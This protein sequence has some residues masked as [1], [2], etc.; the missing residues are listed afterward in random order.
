MRMKKA[1]REF[2]A[3]Q[4][5]CRVATVSR[6]GTPHNVPVCPILEGERI[7]F[8]SEAGA[9]KVQNIR[10]TGQVALAFDEY[11]EAWSGLKGVLIRGKGK[12][13]ESGPTFRRIRKLLY[14]RF[15]QYEGYAALEEKDTVIVEV[16][17]TRAFSW[18][19]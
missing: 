1:E 18:G 6:N 13:I 17:P 14:L 8:A 9:V 7:Y 12:T 3:F 10:A 19:L 2:L 16:T 5:V 15:P 11:T 4:R